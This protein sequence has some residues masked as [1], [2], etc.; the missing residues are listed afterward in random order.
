MGM[1][2]AMQ[3]FPLRIT[4]L[5]DHAEREHGTRE[6]VAARSDG[7]VHRTNW[8][9][10]ADRA[11]R[12]AQVLER[13]GIK[14]G[15]RVATLAMNHDR[16][17]TAW[18][19]VV[20]MG[21][22]LHTLNP[23]LFDDQLEYIVNHGEDQVLLYD[24]AF[25]ELLQRMKPRWTTIRHYVRF[26]DQFDDLLEAENGDYRWYEGD[27]RD[28]CG[29][30][31]TSGTTG[32]PKGV[33]YEHRSTVLHA[34][35][36]VGPDIFNTSARSVMLPV[37]P[38]FHANS[39][40]IPYA[41]ALAGFKLVTCADN[42]PERLCRLFHEEGV[43]HT[44]GVPTVWLSMIDH[45]EKTGA[46]LDKLEIVIIGGSSAPPATIR[47]FNER[48]IR[49]NHLW[50]MTE[51]SPVGTVGAPPGCWDQMSEEEQF[52]YLTRP[53]RSMFGVELRTVD[54]KGDVLPRD[55]RSSGRLQTRGAA[56]VKRYFKQS[57]DCVD[58]DQ[59]FDTGDMATIHPD[60]SIQ[61]TDRAKDVIKSGG[62]WIS[63]IDIENAAVACPGV[64]EA[65]AI[66]IPHPKWDERPLLVVVRDDDS[67]VSEAEIR[68]FLSGQMAKWWL[69]DAIEFTDA[70]PHT[71][72]GKLSK[73]DLRDRYRDYRFADAEAMVG[74][75]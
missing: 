53:G 21:G 3:D 29:L 4:R 20:G 74:R 13:M 7:T 26:D 30:C 64:A 47:W 8:I 75:D 59:W 73:K 34:M 33:L 14:P 63:S 60:G 32:D 51:M 40:C 39:W 23:R 56:V 67:H 68:A 24:A 25:E 41:A 71:A 22:V 48:G 43:T 54:D 50:G 31:Y 52:A 2:G 46:P 1:L 17:L 35:T 11:R 44:A 57:A 15:E 38:M 62:E 70:L 19:G 6:I 9:E 16:H 27:E 45:V 69:P 72:T 28:P 12:L 36:V 65:A 10:V 18:F 61:I 66:G 5:I 55:G 49:V 42:T 37:V 58:A